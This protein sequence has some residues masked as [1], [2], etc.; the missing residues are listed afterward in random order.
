MEV[1]LKVPSTHKFSMIQHDLCLTIKSDG[2]IDF[3]CITT[4]AGH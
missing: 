2:P 1:I 3:V 4:Q